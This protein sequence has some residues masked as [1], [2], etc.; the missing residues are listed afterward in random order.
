MTVLETILENDKKSDGRKKI[1]LDTVVNNY[2]RT[3]EP[4]GSKMVLENC[5]L[6]V[7]SATVRH[8]L[9]ELEKEGYLTHIHTSSGRIPTDKGYR[10]FVDSLMN[11]QSFPTEQQA[12]FEASI[13]SFGS[14]VESILVQ[15]TDILANTIDYTTIVITPT[16]YQDILKVIHLILIDIGQILVVLLNSIGVNR[17]FVMNS[18]ADISQDDLNKLS[19]LLTERLNGKNFACIDEEIFKT[20]IA[21]LPEFHVLLKGLLTEVRKMAKVINK[22]KQMLIKGTANMLKLPEFQNIEL[23]R[24][25]LETLEDTKLLG[26]VLSAALTDKEARVLIGKEH[27]VQNLDECSIVMAPIEIH[28]DSVGVIGV[29]GPKRMAYPVVVPMIKNIVTMIRNFVD[30][31]KQKNINSEGGAVKRD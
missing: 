18:S 5:E 4:V 12:L 27:N 20:L 16:I 22:D 10:L 11:V 31:Y 24:K 8:E 15:M 7:S 28:D 1:I 23:T 21:E 13:H 2:I 3:A 14:N 17:E 29:L 26:K 9:N 6:Q 30:Q 25:I 19:R